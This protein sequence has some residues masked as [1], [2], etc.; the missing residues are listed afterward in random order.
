MSYADGKGLYLNLVGEGGCRGPK[1]DKDPR[2]PRFTGRETLD[3]CASK[4]ADDDDCTAIH[5]LRPDDT[6]G[7]VECLHF[8]HDKVMSVPRLG[9]HCYEMDDDMEHEDDHSDDGAQVE[10]G[11]ELVRWSVDHRDRLDSSL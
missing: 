1:W 8:R 3:Q 4:C 7:T 9:G 2:W 6:D 5:V 10:I 11:E